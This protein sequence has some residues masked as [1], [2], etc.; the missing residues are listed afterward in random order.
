MTYAVFDGVT[1]LTGLE[2]ALFILV[3]IRVVQRM[4]VVP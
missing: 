2:H 1:F 4:D 3:L